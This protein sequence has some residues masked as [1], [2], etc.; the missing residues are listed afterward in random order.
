[1]NST[2]WMGWFNQWLKRHPVKSLPSYLQ[3]G[4]TEEVLR[5][6]REARRPAPVLAWIPVPHFSLAL[7]AAAA[8]A[9]LVVVWTNQAPDRL[10]L[11]WQRLAELG[12]TVEPNEETHLLEEAKSQ[13]QILLPPE[14]DSLLAK[15]EA[16]SSAPHRDLEETL[17]LLE[18]AD[19]DSLS[20]MGEPSSDEQDLLEQLQSLDETELS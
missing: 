4:Y 17:D 12:E 1:M 10:A 19:P 15:A 16:I 2:D 7:A 13:D 8:C 9:V 11:E 3:A 18:Q 20:G 5:R 6:I 14:A